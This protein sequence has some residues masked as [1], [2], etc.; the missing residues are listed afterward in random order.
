MLNRCVLS[1]AYSPDFST[2]VSLVRTF[3]L[4]IKRASP[5]DEKSLRS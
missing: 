1:R 3:A 4:V 2:P 5:R